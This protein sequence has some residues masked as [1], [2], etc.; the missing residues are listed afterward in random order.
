L[1]GFEVGDLKAQIGQILGMNW[2]VFWAFF[3]QGPIRA[4]LGV[5]L[6][7]KGGSN[8]GL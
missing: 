7:Q 4:D 1:W 5:I 8:W 6:Q 2:K 3:F